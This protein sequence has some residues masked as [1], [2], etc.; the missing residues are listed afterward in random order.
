ME[1][2]TLQEIK[3]AVRGDFESS[4][5]QEHV[6]G[7]STDTR[8]LVTG[9]LF[10]AIKGPRFDGHN[11]ISQARKKGA[12]AVICANGTVIDTAICCIVVDDTLQ[13]LGDLAAHY[14]KKFST[15]VIA[16]TGSNGKT[17]TKDMI[18]HVLSASTSVVKSE[19][20]LNNLI[21]LPLSIFQ[22]DPNRTFA[23][24]EMGANA[25]GEISRL[26]KI[27]APQIAV[28]T[29][30]SETHLE[31]L[32]DIDGVA[33]AKAEIVHGMDEEGF[34]IVNGDDERC[35]AIGRRFGGRMAT[36]GFE[37]DVDIRCVKME[38][39]GLRTVFHLADG[40]VVDLP[41]LGS[42]NVLN[43]LACITACI[44]TGAN[45]ESAVKRLAFFVAPE[46]RGRVTRSR[47][48]TLI[49]DA[50]NAN[51]ASFRAA[52]GV[53][54]EVDASRHVFVCGDM[55]ELGELSN[56]FHRNLGRFVA[57]SGMDIVACVGKAARAVGE[58]A[59]A[60]GM[61]Q[62]QVL[63]FETAGEAAS[64]ITGLLRKG[65]AV[66]VKGSRAMGMEVIADVITEVN[67]AV[68]SSLAS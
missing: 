43:A 5:G 17:T 26:S 45:R 20:N 24:L 13:A 67:N 52:M 8:T 32:K 35:L 27:A 23:V 47:G 2:L 61:S 7:I 29:C 68:P 53:L 42:H 1:R 65:D 38:V 12:S 19:E 39:N 64:A 37:E 66:L 58:E 49:N 18:H 22:I 60:K 6:T 30:I 63:F 33:A 16:V 41:L 4:A 44:R 46:M 36:F 31:G 62:S 28:I 14:R 21:G 55:K 48:I 54:L 11:Y 40:T 9:D 25:P 59:I 10:V 50:Y 15:R 56:L 51:P 57:H 3:D 34:L